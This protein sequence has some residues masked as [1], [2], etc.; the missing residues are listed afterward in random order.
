MILSIL[1]YNLFIVWPFSTSSFFR[2]SFFVW[3]MWIEHFFLVL[4]LRLLTFFVLTGQLDANLALPPL[5]NYSEWLRGRH[6]L[7]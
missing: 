1:I 6:F 7:H 3:R 4:F 5:K 2:L